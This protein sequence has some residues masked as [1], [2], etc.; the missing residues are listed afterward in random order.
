[1]KLLPAFQDQIKHLGPLRRAWFT[2]FNLDIEFFETYVLPATMGAERP[3][4]RL[5]FEQLQHDVTQKG[6]DVRIF[7]DPRFLDTHRMK[8]TCVPVHGVR[9]ERADRFG[10]DSLFHPKV[11]FLEDCNGERVVGVGSANMTLSGWG[12]NVEAFCF[13]SLNNR[14][15]YRDVRAFFQE[16]CSLAAVDQPWARATFPDQKSDWR[17]VHS[18]Q[19]KSFAAQMLDDARNGDLVVW[20]P[21]LPRDLA[22]FVSKLAKMGES[23]RLNVHIVPDRIQGRFLRTEW[24]AELEA[25][26]ASGRLKFYEPPLTTD[27]KSILRHA[28]LWK[29]AGRLAV[30]SWNFTGPGSNCMSSDADGGSANNI[31]AG[32]IIDDRNAW[33]DACGKPLD[34][35]RE[36][37]ASAEL[38]TDESLPDVPLPPFDLQVSFDWH[39]HAYRFDGQW[40]GSGAHGMFSV[41]LPGIGTVPL[42]WRRDGTP[43]QPG[44]LALDEKALLRDRVFRVHDG[45]RKV[46]QG[47][48]TER[49]VASRT[50]Q[51]FS[52]LNELLEASIHGDDRETLVHLPFRIPMDDDGLTDD[53]HPRGAEDDELKG[54][55][56]TPGS[57]ISY[58]RF[59]QA[60]AAYRRKLEAILSLELLDREV[61]FVPGSLVELIEK[62]REAIEGSESAV[63]K[64][65][66]GCEVSSLCRIAHERR[67]RL[68]RPAANR[69]S[70]YEA[71]PKRRW[72]AVAIAE[73]AKPAGVSP[74]YSE[75]VSEVCGYD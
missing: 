27:P 3:R 21:Y 61:F 70:N 62:V 49:N 37:F 32:F 2:S 23:E 60:M 33:R 12:R 64:W 41:E 38:L 48:V 72:D 44:A 8:R 74:S 59:F 25:M 19:K 24:S 9:P 53:M 30:G 50:A 26:T 52:D 29:I 18:F 68:G 5:E 31:E 40:L 56:D 69:N 47:L 57:T 63:F 20:S 43:G 54:H 73:P 35:G 58:Y 51:H 6:V 75:R 36:D 42:K 10:E 17:F 39:T 4:S 28:K 16:L 66:L 67:R 15:N 14:E 45:D 55:E 7:C 1:M 22:G 46:H 65:F 13:R 34:I 71:V 11:I